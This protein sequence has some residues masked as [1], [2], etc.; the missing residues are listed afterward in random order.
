M[1]AYVHIGTPKTG[2]TT[3]QKFLALNYKL[4]TTKKYLFPKQKNNGNHFPLLKTCF[5]KNKRIEF[6]SSFSSCIEIT[7]ECK[8]NIIEAYKTEIKN[9]GAEYIVFSCEN[10]SINIE[11]LDELLRLKSN[12]NSLGIRNIYIVIY[13]RDQVKFLSSWYSQDIKHGGYRKDYLKNPFYWNCFYNMCNYENIIQM[14]S[15]VFGKENLIVRLFEKEEFYEQDLLKDFVYSIGLKWDEKFV[16]PM[17]QNESLNLIGME[18]LKSLNRLIPRFLNNNALDPFR[19]EIQNLIQEKFTV[20][21]KELKFKPSIKTVN[22]YEQL[23]EESNEWIRKE[24]FPNKER[25]FPKENLSNYKENYEIKEMKSE[26]W[27][28]IID[29]VISMVKIKNTVIADKDN[30]VQI[31]EKTITSL[32]SQLEN[33]QNKNKHFQKLNADLTN[34][35]KQNKLELQQIQSQIA[36]QIKYGTAKAR[37]Q[38]QLSYKLG[39]AMII[40]SKSILGY[41]RMPFVLSYIKDKHKQEQ[42]IYQEKIKKDPSL[43]LP[44]LE[45]Y[46]DYKEALKEKECLA[47]KLGQALIQANKTWHKGGYIGLLFKINKLKKDFKKGAR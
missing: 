34:E 28:Q 46:S 29:F 36:F 20:F 10:L 15:N 40:N 32:H 14:Y 9:A 45:S 16:I 35:I 8:K 38:N 25:L 1:T 42:K 4:L 24:F 37:I 47:Y 44:T 6:N 19:I 39:R 43:A 7:Q 3:I 22:L 11:E 12:I 30:S 5:K 21:N 2:T 26:Y 41:I 18:L 17:D 23:F 27:D 33:L 13:L 31:K